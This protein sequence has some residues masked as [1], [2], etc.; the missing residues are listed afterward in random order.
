M[1]MGVGGET[2]KLTEI[3]LNVLNKGGI[4]LDSSEFGIL[5]DR[6]AALKSPIEKKLPSAGY[7]DCSQHIIR[8]MNTRKYYSYISL[9][10]TANQA[11]SLSLKE[12]C[13]NKIE[14]TSP[15]CAKYLREIE[16]GYLIYPHLKKIKFWGQSTSNIIEQLFGEFLEERGLTTIYHIF[17]S[18][19]MKSA[20]KCNKEYILAQSCQNIHT[21]YA[22]NRVEEKNLQSIGAEFVVHEISSQHKTYQIIDAVHNAAVGASKYFYTINLLEGSCTCG[23]IEQESLPCIHMQVLFRYLESNNKGV[24][25]QVRYDSDIYYGKIYK[26]AVWK[27]LFVDFTPNFPSIEAVKS[28]KINNP[29]IQ[30]LNCPFELTTDRITNARITSSGDTKKI[31]STVSSNFAKGIVGKKLC[32]QCG[33]TYGAKSR[34]FTNASACK[35]NILKSPEYHNQLHQNDRDAQAKYDNN[36]LCR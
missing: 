27:E 20:D 9:F 35:K 25:I 12:W 29:E 4:L 2:C 7:L 32:K 31:G 24:T 5:K 17:L 6:G 30:K 3:T 16:H 11:L 14:E 15:A 10:Q 1:G 13:L 22:E 8:N 33:K 36:K 26:T 34:H 18:F 21:P 28:Y 19:L 23:S